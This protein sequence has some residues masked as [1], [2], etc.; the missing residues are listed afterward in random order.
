MSAAPLTDA[1]LA[2]MEERAASL[3][4]DTWGVAGKLSPMLVT[5]LRGVIQCGDDIDDTCADYGLRL[6]T[7]PI[8]YVTDDPA[9]RTFIAHAR[10]D[11]PRLLAELRRLRGM[12]R[13]YASACDVI[14]AP[15]ATAAVETWE[16][17]QVAHEAAR[18]ALYAEGKR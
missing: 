17:A 6:A 5:D 2:A 15:T 3:P 16:A 14:D 7:F 11:V 18:D 13:D 1:D 12:L 8:G 10:E 9:V 4:G